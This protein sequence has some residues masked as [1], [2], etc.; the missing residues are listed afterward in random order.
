MRRLQWVLIAA[1]A[2]GSLAIA[3]MDE[4]GG[5]GDGPRVTGKFEPLPAPTYHFTRIDSLMI[6]G[7]R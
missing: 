6:V 1:L 7:G 2:A 4:T 3:W 5:P